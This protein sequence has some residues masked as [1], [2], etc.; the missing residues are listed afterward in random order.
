MT[1]SESDGERRMMGA[2]LRSVRRLSIAILL[3]GTILQVPLPLAAQPMDAV[4]DTR[5]SNPTLTDP[6]QVDF[7]QAKHRYT[8]RLSDEHHPFDPRI[9]RFVTVPRQSGHRMAIGNQSSSA[10]QNRIGRRFKGYSETLHGNDPSPWEQR[11]ALAQGGYYVAAGLWPILHM[12]SFERVTGPKTDDWLVKT[13]GAMIA[14]VGGGLVYSRLRDGPS[15]DLQVVAVGSAAALTIVD[16]T[17]VAQGRISRI[18]LLDA[19]AELALIVGWALA[20]D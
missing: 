12:R 16:V 9:D 17:Y 14:V 7:R 19:V 11:L 3:L 2:L 20:W 5:L 4:A 13:V 10:V 15:N 6:R 1:S 18:Y 8:E